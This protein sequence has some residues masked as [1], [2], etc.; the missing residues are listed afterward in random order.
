M[1]KKLGSFG[2][3]SNF[4]FYYAHHLSTIEGGMICSNNKLIYESARMFR[5]HGMLRESDSIEYKNKII[6]KN[7]NLNPSFIFLKHGFNMRNNEIGALIGQNQL[8]RLNKNIKRRN[9][10]FYFFL[11]NIN[12]NKYFVNFDLNGSSNYAFNLIQIS[13]SK[14]EFN[15]LT[16]RLKKHK[17]E[18]RVGSAGG[19]NQLRQPYLK[20]F[21]KK[22]KIKI[23]DF[24]NTEKVH[25]FGMY[26]GNYPDLSF[27]NIKKICDII[28]QS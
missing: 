3:I 26:I 28:N 23:S 4:S 17:I 21:V 6:K 2:I 16:D 11:K 20:E 15:K 1:K 10:N 18:F 9:E 8:K 12:S 13:N 14:I 25:F 5:G 7:K 24:T 22:N 27:K 19:G